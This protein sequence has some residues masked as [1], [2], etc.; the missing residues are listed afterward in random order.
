LL[1]SAKG[2]TYYRLS[3]QRGRRVHKHR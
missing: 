2:G 1:A 3:K